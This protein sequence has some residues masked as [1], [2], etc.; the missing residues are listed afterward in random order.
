VAL[1]VLG[2]FYQH[3]E[4][5]PQ[6]NVLAYMMFSIA[7]ARGYEGSSYMLTNLQKKMTPEDIAKGQELAA[8]WVPG[9]P[10]PT[11]Y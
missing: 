8:K 11:K 9:T 6:S 5:V 2:N 1:D 4:G 10:L 7:S 3:G